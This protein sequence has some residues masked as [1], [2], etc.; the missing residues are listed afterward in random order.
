MSLNTLVDNS[1]TDKQRSHGYLD[2]YETLLSSKKHTAKNVLEVG[3]G[4][5]NLK[6]G[7]S[8]KLWHDYFK[9]A[10]IYGIDI[11][12]MDRV[13]DELQNNER[14][15]LFTSVDAYDLSF[16]TNNILNSGI[17][18][19]VLLDDGPHTLDSIQNFVLLYSQVISDDGILIIED[20]QKMEYTKILANLVPDNLKKYIEIYDLRNVRQCPDNIVFVINKNKLI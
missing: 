17:K 11:L 16:F 9:T 8:I 5:F 6:N 14:V 10:T 19:D 2:L 12:S 1:L 20:V 13:I 18:F 3:I 15:K 7:G 4:D